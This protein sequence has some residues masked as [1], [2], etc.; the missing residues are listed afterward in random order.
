[1]C[2]GDNNSD[3]VVEKLDKVAE[4]LET[5]TSHLAGAV[6]Q[7]QLDLLRERIAKIE[8]DIST[9]KVPLE[10][11]TSKLDNN[12]NLS[13]SIDNKFKESLE[14]MEKDFSGLRALSLT[15]FALGTITL[16]GLIL[17]A[18]YL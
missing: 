3:N 1:V 4:S 2:M 14:L 12:I 8:T 17:C 9:Y 5:A 15:G 7:Q 13:E 10:T 18:V 6:T 16:I 11:L